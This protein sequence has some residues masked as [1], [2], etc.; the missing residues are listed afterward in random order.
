VARDYWVRVTTKSETQTT[1]CPPVHFRWAD[2]DYDV[3]HASIVPCNAN[4]LQSLRGEGRAETTADDNYRTLRL[5]FA[6]Y[7]SARA[8][9]TIRFQPNQFA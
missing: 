5:V 1:R 7:D 9:Q 3:V 6:A 8:H 2:P 4:L